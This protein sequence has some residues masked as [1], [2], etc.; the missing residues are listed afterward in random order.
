M[1]DDAQRFAELSFDDFRRMARD[2]SL[3]SNEKIGFP[4][5]YRQGHEPNIFAD[6][7]RKVPALAERNKLILDIGPGCSELSSL[8]VERCR[9]AGHQLVLVDSQEMLEHIADEPFIHKLPAFYPDCDALF[10]RYRGAMDGIVVYSVFHYMFKEANIWTVLDR[11]MSLL[12]HG[13][14]LLFGDIPNVSKRK[15][16][17]SSTTGIRFHQA[18][19]RQDGDVPQVEWNRIEPVKIDDGVLLGLVMRARLAGYDAYMVPQDPALPMANRREDL[20]IV[21]P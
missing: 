19:T 21:R 18:F 12:K 1:N 6:I 13:G 8:L 17:F 7:V 2:E 14:A 20:L 5:S 3:T 16:F 10:E 9:T 15:R 11:S 4:D